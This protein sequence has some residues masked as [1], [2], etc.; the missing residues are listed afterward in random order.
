MRLL[1]RVI[2]MLFMLAAAAVAL[3]DA[4][5]WYKTGNLHPTLVGTLTDRLFTALQVAQADVQHAVPPWL[6]DNVIIYLFQLWA[7]PTLALPG[8]IL[9]WETRGRRRAETRLD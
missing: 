6:W 7:A 5:D 9:L 3:N 1:G 8:L 4:F 2:A